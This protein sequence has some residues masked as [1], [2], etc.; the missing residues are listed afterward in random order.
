MFR[1]TFRS[2]RLHRTLHSSRTLLAD[3]K[4]VLESASGYASKALEQSQR[5]AQVIG[6]TTGSLLQRAGPQV[7]GL[8]GR[9]ARLQRPIV[10]WGR[11]AGEVGKQGMSRVS[12]TLTSVYL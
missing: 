3:G 12:K 7:N 6:T 1:Q 8:L 9:F 2:Q 5:V 4:P 11:V 10:H